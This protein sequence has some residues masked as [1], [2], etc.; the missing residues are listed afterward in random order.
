MQRGTFNWVDVHVVI[1]VAIQGTNDTKSALRPVA[2]RQFEQESIVFR[3]LWT[4]GLKVRDR[5]AP[6]SN[7]GPRPI[8]E[9]KPLDWTTLY[10]IARLS[11]VVV[12]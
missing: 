1:H 5:E 2:E 10:L 11:S 12:V 9:L 6:G 4:K 3:H 8:F 7:P